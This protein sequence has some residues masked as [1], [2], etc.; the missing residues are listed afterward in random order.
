MSEP[1]LDERNPGIVALRRD[2][3]QL[4]IGL[5]GELG[6]RFPVDPAALSSQVR[7]ETPGDPRSFERLVNGIAVGLDLPVLRKLA[8]LNDPLPERAI[9]LTQILR[10]RREALDFLRPYRHLAAHPGSN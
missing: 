10:S 4:V 7:V 9:H 6:D 5:A 2:L 1:W 8:L 3:T